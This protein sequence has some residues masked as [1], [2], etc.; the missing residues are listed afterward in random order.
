[1]LDKTD[2][3]CIIIGDGISLK[4]FDI[5]LFK[6]FNVIPIA[7]L[8]F[9]KDVKHLKIDNS[10][11]LEP[12]WMYP[13]MRFPSGSGKIFFNPIQKKYKK[14]IKNNPLTKF[15][16][17]RSNYPSLI[18]NNNIEFIYRQLIF[19]EM[20]AHS[21]YKNFDC[22]KGSFRFGIALAIYLGFK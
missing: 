11:L 18:F 21:L 10:I 3:T 7:F 16:I 22:F 6:D 14:I 15:Y 5:K 4:W 2:K 9:H 20:N 12:F 19:S 17:D 8:W 1:L 13:I